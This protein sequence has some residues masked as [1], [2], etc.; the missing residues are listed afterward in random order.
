MCDLNNPL[1]SEVVHNFSNK[2]VHG[3]KVHDSIAQDLTGIHKRIENYE[4]AL[5]AIGK[6][7]SSLVSL[8]KMIEKTKSEFLLQRIHQSK[9]HPI[10][11]T[12]KV[13]VV[14]GPKFNRIT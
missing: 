10:I 3:I 9:I 4:G 7:K 6:A 1:L 13:F 14:K 12:P 8:E 11:E 5:E 2:E